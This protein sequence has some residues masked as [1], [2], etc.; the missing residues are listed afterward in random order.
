[1]ASEPVSLAVPKSATSISYQNMD[2]LLRQLPETEQSEFTEAMASANVP[3][4]TQYDIL[5]I[6]TGNED[7]PMTR[8]AVGNVAK[9]L[10]IAAKI[11]KGAKWLGKQENSEDDCGV[12][13]LCTGDRFVDKQAIQTLQSYRSSLWR[14]WPSYMT[15][16]SGWR[17]GIVVFLPAIRYSWHFTA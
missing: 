6:L 11:F 10:K 15:T 7:R 12:F 13:T 3:V 5:Q 4:T 2:Q 1:M 8:G 17:V 16:N 14:P 9:A